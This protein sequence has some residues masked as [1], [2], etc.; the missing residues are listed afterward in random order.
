[1]NTEEKEILWQDRKRLWCGLPWTF[2]HYRLENEKLFVKRGFL[3]VT[4]DEIRLYRIKDV[5]VKCTFLQRVFGIGTIL[6][7][8]S[9]MSMGNFLNQNV[10]KPE[11][12]W[13]LLSDKVEE[14]RQQ[15]RVG[16]RELYGDASENDE[17][18]TDA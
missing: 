4:N 11:E 13:K 12:V 7:S 14:Q 15:K 3:T 2:T 8:S 1:M 5:S 17:W 6:V 10:R 18:D 16:V 9:D